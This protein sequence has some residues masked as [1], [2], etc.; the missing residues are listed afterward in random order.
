MS[1]ID[2]IVNNG[3]AESQAWYDE[4]VTVSII[5][6]ILS[7]G[8][9]VGVILLERRFDKRRELAKVDKEFQDLKEFFFQSVTGL[10]AGISSQLESDN[11]LLTFIKENP[12]KSA[13]KKTISSFHTRRFDTLPPLDVYKA[14]THNPKLDAEM[15]S[16]TILSLYA[17][18][19]VVE[20]HKATIDESLKFCERKAEEILTRYYECLNN[21]NNIKL[22]WANN[23][24]DNIS[25]KNYIQRVHNIWKNYLG[26]KESLA[27]KGINVAE[28]DLELTFT[29]LSDELYKL[30]L[31]SDTRYFPQNKQIVPDVT[32][33]YQLK[34]EYGSIKNYFE[35][36]VESSI[37]R[38][39]DLD[40]NI[41]EDY[42]VL[43]R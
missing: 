35:R 40:T 14:F 29:M 41:R 19:D 26:Y 18:L 42:H 16:R 23:P 20:Q 4:P 38:L 31:E 37:N 21:L 36:I 22:E 10:L 33:M 6:S 17:S 13:T 9:A 28:L 12:Y 27:K 15:I 43:K 32:K 1:L 8:I 5:S 25:Y 39:I 34:A 7:A 3:N 30:I 2:V 24:T 11:Q